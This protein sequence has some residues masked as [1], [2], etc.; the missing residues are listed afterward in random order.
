MIF[1]VLIVAACGGLCCIVIIM[2]GTIVYI[3]RKNKTTCQPE[4]TM[5]EAVSEQ[6]ELRSDRL[7]QPIQVRHQYESSSSPID[8]NRGAKESVSR[9]GSAIYDSPHAPIDRL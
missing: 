4:K 1:F 6:S 7:K 2:A 5:E 3:M 8:D 9:Q